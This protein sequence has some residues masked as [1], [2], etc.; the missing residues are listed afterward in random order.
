MKRLYMTGPTCIAIAAFLY[1]SP[2]ASQDTALVKRVKVQTDS[3]RVEAQRRQGVRVTVVRRLATR[4]DSIASAY[5]P[6][7]DTVLVP[8]PPEQPSPPDT[9]PSPP[10]TAVTPPSDTTPTPPP[11]V[12]P[13]PAPPMDTARFDGAAELPRATVAIPAPTGGRVLRVAAGTNLQTVLDSARRGDVIAL[14][15]GATFVGSFKLRAKPGSVADG[16]ITLT[17]DAPI[18]AGR[19][20]PTVAAAFAKLRTPSTEPAVETLR[21]A[22]GWL[23]R[24]LDVGALTGVAENYGL[25]V[26]D[27][28]Y[29]VSVLADIPTDVV[30]DR[31]YVHGHDALNVSRC[32]SLQ[33]ARTA[34]VDSYLAEC[35]ARDRDAQ[36]IG[37][38][39]GTGPYL[40]QNNYLEGS[41]EI[42]MFGG[43]DPALN[44]VSPSD[45]TIRG[46][47]ITRPLAWHVTPRRW[48]VKNLMELK[49]ARRV[50][51]ERNTFS[52][53]WADAQD[54]RAFV[55]QSI[56]QGGGWGSWSTVQDVTFRY[57]RVDN[58]PGVFNIAER[59]D[60]SEVPAARLTIRGNVFS[61]VGAMPGT[62]G[63]FMLQGQ[64]PGVTITDN[65][66]FGAGARGGWFQLTA[67]RWPDLI[68]KR[69]IGG[70][71][72][73]VMQAPNGNDAALLTAYGIPAA[74]FAGNCLVFPYTVT[75]AGNVT[76]GS[77]AA[78][79]LDAQLRPLA[80]SPCA[81][82]GADHSLVP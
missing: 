75:L 28:Q 69:N 3:L 36:A 56:N 73:Y 67:G 5:R 42:I 81:G 18:P 57:N 30:L 2:L 4:L 53:H 14:A 31:V 23:L 1:T 80:G 51:I 46:N 39:G 55:F 38:W 47:T 7:V 6:R 77:R 9:S 40:I 50:L 11:P 59:Y 49:H 45:I 62:A 33:S 27:A 25:V 8:A 35:H 13:S 21:G 19:V 72:A 79:M 10:D 64:I 20:T 12:P 68:V 34:I 82:A 26:L 17:T 63:V 60:G 41:G 54:G 37:G 22:E 44:G 76:L 74:N 15:P 58:V 48:L 71:A 16:W 32:V 52:N 61:R 78:A 66:G 29:A 24:G 65:T 43:A 70:D